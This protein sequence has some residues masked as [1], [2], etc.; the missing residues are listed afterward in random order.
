MSYVIIGV[1]GLA[2]KPP[3]NV[4]AQGWI[5]AMKEGLARNCS[6]SLPTIDYTPVHWAHLRYEK[7]EEPDPE[8]YIPT[9]LDE[10]IKTYRD[11]WLSS[12]R[13]FISDAP[14]D[15]IE[16][17][18]EWFGHH[19]V[20]DFVL[21][22]KLKDLDQYYKDGA[23]RKNLRTLVK[24]AILG[25]KNKRITLIAH[26]MGSIVAY[27][28]LRELGQIDSNYRIENFV[29]IGS[30]LGL[31]TVAVKMSEEWALLRT[32]SMVKRWINFSDPRDPVAFDTHLWN[33][34]EAND[35]GVRV[36]DD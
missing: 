34:Y 19:P 13:A 10:P 4:H 25:E 22:K 33:D 5:A 31:P 15:I 3:M 17:N 11:G 36:V 20:T 1:H 6:L 16:K 12:I 2:N 32:P 28:A 29:T 9:P 14:G 27:D 24:D 30:P 8:P 7:P 23:Y 18:K 21:A 35:Q 26:S